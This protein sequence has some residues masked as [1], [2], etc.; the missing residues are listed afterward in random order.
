MN[1]KILLL[2]IV[3]VALGIAG[4]TLLYQWQ[5]GGLAQQN[6]IQV[7]FDPNPK[8]PFELEKVHLGTITV[9][10]GGELALAIKKE[11]PTATDNLR[12]AV[13]DVQSQKSLKLSGESF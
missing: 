5:D 4:C 11:V 8:D 3:I 12:K 9:G 2:V 1:K 7:Y 6:T 10:L 13:T